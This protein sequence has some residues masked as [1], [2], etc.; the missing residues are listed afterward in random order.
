MGRA[1]ICFIFSVII[2]LN[3]VI[4]VFYVKPACSAWQVY[5]EI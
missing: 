5:E 3:I 4:Q 1:F 2:K